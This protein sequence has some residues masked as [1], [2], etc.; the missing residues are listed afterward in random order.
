MHIKVTIDY[1][2]KVEKL[3]CTE[4]C[5]YKFYCDISHMIHAFSFIS[6]AFI[7]NTRLKFVKELADAKQYPQGDKQENGQ[8]WQKWLFCACN[9]LKYRI[10]VAPAY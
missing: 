3:R 6:N 1:S 7:S 8:T 4:N 10:S 9:N 2:I 5:V